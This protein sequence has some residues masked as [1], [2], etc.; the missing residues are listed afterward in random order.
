VYKGHLNELVCQSTLTKNAK[1]KGVFRVLFTGN[2]MESLIPW[3]LLSKISI[4]NVDHYRKGR[5]QDGWRLP[6]T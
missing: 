3:M 1:A 5:R 2:R 4:L 6:G